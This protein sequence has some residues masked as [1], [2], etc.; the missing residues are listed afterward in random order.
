VAVVAQRLPLST[1]D[2]ARVEIDLARELADIP[3][4]LHTAIVVDGSRSV[5]AE[6]AEAQRAI[7]AA[8]LR[9]APQGRVQLIAYA[10]RAQALLPGWQNASSAAARVDRELRALESRNG[11]NVDAGLVAAGEWL[12]RVPGTHRVIVFTDERVGDRLASY[13]AAA[14]K[15]LLP[16]GTL[17]HVV[18]L[19]SGDRGLDHDDTVM[20][21][22]LAVATEGIGVRGQVDANGEVDATLL[23][24]P[25]ELEK[26][27]VHAPGW[28]TQATFAE[29]TCEIAN[30][31]SLARGRS[32]TWWGQ[33]TA[34]AGPVTI[35]GMLWNSK[36]TRVVRPDPAGARTLARR[37]VAAAELP[38]DVQREVEL[39]AF[40]LDS[41]WAMLATWGGKGGYSDAEEIGRIGL[42]RFSTCGCD[43]GVGT[44]GHGTGS[45]G[46]P[47]LDLRA[48][49]AKA[50]AAC[51]PGA[52]SVKIDLETTLQEI[53][54]VDVTIAHG[55]PALHD[56]VVEGVW[57][58][59]LAIPNAPAHAHTSFVI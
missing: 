12:S 42:G 7:A 54:D 40:A 20:F 52:A 37:L 51:Q 32:C 47:R 46:T 49:L 19:E 36:L 57:D 56:C 18:A 53:V 45:I 8:Y 26:I 28:D 14:L 33:G 41:V 25:I 58:T 34:V 27:E 15:N 6:Q 59:F 5:T 29:E 16:A 48:Q 13:D 22:A 44:I 38:A 21:G 1:M 43:D 3:A 30:A 35:T 2:F 4:D 50:V 31:P 10:R 24:R 9:A 55:P 23:A 11:S 17:A 39:A